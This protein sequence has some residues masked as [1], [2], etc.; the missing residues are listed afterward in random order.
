M[1]GGAMHQFEQRAAQLAFFE[2]LGHQHKHVSLLDAMAWSQSEQ[3][4]ESLKCSSRAPVLVL[5][6]SEQDWPM[7]SIFAG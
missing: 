1:L 4:I 2:G 3:V 5:P 7:R 6:G